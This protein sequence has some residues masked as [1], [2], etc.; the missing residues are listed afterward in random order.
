MN[1]LNY[2]ECFIVR[3]LLLIQENRCK[4]F[5]KENFGSLHSYTAD[6]IGHI[7]DGEAD[8]STLY[9]ENYKILVWERVFHWFSAG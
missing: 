9:Y 1:Q 2:F 8:T 7:G 3:V 6:T 4:I 5:A